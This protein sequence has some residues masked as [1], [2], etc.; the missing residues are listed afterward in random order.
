MTTNYTL[1]EIEKMAKEYNALEAYFEKKLSKLDWGHLNNLID[2]HT[3]LLD[4]SNKS[5]V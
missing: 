4:T 1:K 3:E 5:H 2:L